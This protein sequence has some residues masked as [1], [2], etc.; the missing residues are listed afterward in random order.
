MVGNAVTTNLP[1]NPGELVTSTWPT[2]MPRSSL[3][4]AKSSQ[5]GCK[6]LHAGHQGAKLKFFFFNR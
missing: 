6:A 5:T 4:E 1:D 3:Q 2:E